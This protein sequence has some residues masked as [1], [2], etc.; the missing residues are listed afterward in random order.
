MHL[1]LF[2]MLRGERKHLTVPQAPSTKYF[3]VIL[4]VILKTSFLCQKY[5]CSKVDCKCPLNSPFSRDGVFCFI[6]SAELS[7]DIELEC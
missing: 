7:I 2:P 4:Y 3:S 5:K 6:S 1:L